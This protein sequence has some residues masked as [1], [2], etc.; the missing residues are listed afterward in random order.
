MLTLPAL[1]TSITLFTGAFSSLASDLDD[2]IESAVKKSYVFKTYL[3]GDS[4]QTESK[5]G[6]VVLTGMVNEASHR[7]LAENTVEE[8]PG[9]IRVDN[10]LKIR[11]DSP[12][13]HSD[14]WLTM[15]VKSTLLFHRNVS[16]S[17]T[18]VFSKDGV[19]SLR[20]EASS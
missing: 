6:V 5:E 2:R 20:G 14:G 19:V 18:D 1:L 8:M 9:V 4:I 13:V 11:A 10:R 12:P 16:S 15:K 17:G 7:T 3:K